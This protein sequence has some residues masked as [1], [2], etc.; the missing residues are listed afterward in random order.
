MDHWKEQLAPPFFIDF[1]FLSTPTFSFLP[2]NSKFPNS[3]RSIKE[4]KIPI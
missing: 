1:R 3:W 4:L 2:S